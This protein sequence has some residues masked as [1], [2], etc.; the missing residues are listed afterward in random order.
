M[1]PKVEIFE[2][3]YHPYTDLLLSSVPEMDPDWL[4]RRLEERSL[5]KARENA[6]APAA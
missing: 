3:P 1:G 2:P 6:D 5:E 4:T